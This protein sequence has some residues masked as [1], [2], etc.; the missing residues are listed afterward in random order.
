ME[1]LNQRT[2]RELVP[3]CLVAVNLQLDQLLVY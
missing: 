1:Y 2:K 3:V